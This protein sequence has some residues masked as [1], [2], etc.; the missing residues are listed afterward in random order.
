MFA[1]CGAAGCRSGRRCGERLEIRSALLALGLLAAPERFRDQ[2]VGEDELGFGHV[3]DRQ[4]HVG[5]FARRRRR[6]GCAR[7]SPSAPSS[8]PRNRLRP[9]P[10]RHFDLHHVVGVAFEIR[11]PHQ[12]PVDAGRRQLQ[13]IGAVDR[14]GDVEHRR[15][16]A[17]GGLAIL[18]RSSCRRA[19]RPS[20]AR[21]SRRGRRRARAPADSRGSSSTGSDNARRRGR[22][23]R[24]DDQAPLGVRR[25]M[26]RCRSSVRVGSCNLELFR[27]F[28]C[29]GRALGL[30]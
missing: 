3:L 22:Q 10:A 14:I 15:Q 18:D 29:P 7:Q 5:G 16:R 23:S 28:F 20:P 11:A 12:R 1:P 6:A 17:R 4:Q 13:P 27:L 19:A 9:S 26:D 25:A 24:L 8:K 30:G 2:R 21:C